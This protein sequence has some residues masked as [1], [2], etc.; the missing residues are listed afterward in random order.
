MNLRNIL[1]LGGFALAVLSGLALAVSGPGSRFE[2]WNFRVGFALLKWALFGGLLSGA[3]CLAGGAE[4][5]RQH[6]PE[7]LWLAAA[8]LLI[9][10]AIAAIP[11]SARRAAG[12]V[13]PINDI[14]TDTQDPPRFLA[15]LPLRAGATSPADYGGAELAA[16]QLQ[17]YPG[18]KPLTTAFPPAAAFERAL[19]ISKRSG[20]KII[21]AEQAQGRIEAVDTTFWFGFKDDIVIRIRPEGAGSRLDIRSHSRVGKS[22][23]GANAGR[24]MK[25]LAAFRE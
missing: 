22:D 14:T 16:Q 13:P 18:L 2:L 4:A 10:L 7:G 11:L 17:A 1:I 5:L 21:A 25:F 6:K 24:I 9:G 8:G 23:L 12:R 15:V 20:W 3:L 19:L